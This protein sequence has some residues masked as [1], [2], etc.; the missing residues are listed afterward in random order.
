M[1]N[2]DR[3]LTDLKS[4]G[5]NTVETVEKSLADVIIRLLSLYP[6][7]YDAANDDGVV[8]ALYIVEI[9]F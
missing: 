2:I 5:K 7:L 6:C 4:T 8:P 9:R 1:Q 3:Y